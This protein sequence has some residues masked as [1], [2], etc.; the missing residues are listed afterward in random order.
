V[1]VLARAVTVAVRCYAIR[2]QFNDR[3]ATA[4]SATDPE[5][6][7]LDYLTVQIRNLPLFAA[8]S[9][10]HYTGEYMYD[11]YQRGRS[12][13]EGGDFGPLAELHSAS[14]G[15]KI[16]CTTLAADGIETCR[17]TIGGQGFGGGSGLVGVNAE[18]VHQCDLMTIS[19]PH[20][21]LN[22]LSPF[23]VAGDG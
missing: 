8:T 12:T 14:S 10:L 5:K 21:Y 17:R 18:Y 2:R 13:I 23:P 7:V 4:T 19:I 16:L 3:D 15:L 6:Q 11:L 9:A 1:A 22:Y 20:V